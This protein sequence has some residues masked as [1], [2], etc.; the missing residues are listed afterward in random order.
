MVRVGQRGDEGLVE[1]SDVIFATRGPGVYGD[2][3]TNY[4]H[5]KSIAAGGAIVVE[6]NV[7]EP[8]DDQ[9]G[10]GMWDAHIR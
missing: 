6:I 9:A 10:V 7:H 8:A 4:M 1:I 5:I 3:S 2:N